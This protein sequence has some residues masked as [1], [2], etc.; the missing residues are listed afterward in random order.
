M[1]RRVHVKHH[2]GDFKVEEIL[3]FNGNINIS[4]NG[5]HFLWKWCTTMLFKKIKFLLNIVQMCIWEKKMDNLELAFDD[6]LLH[7]KKSIIES[8]SISYTLKQLVFLAEP[9]DSSTEKWWIRKHLFLDT[10]NIFLYFQLKDANGLGKILA[11]KYFQHKKKVWRVATCSLISI[12][13]LIYS[14]RVLARY[15][16]I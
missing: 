8:W 9:S 6:T 7:V 16:A 1:E 3:K 13:Y 11:L 10:L 4:I 12:L 14:N 15:M 5:C 2:L